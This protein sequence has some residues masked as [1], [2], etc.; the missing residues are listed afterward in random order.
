M[1][2]AA[3]LIV[4]IYFVLAL[5]YTLGVAFVKTARECVSSPGSESEEQDPYGEEVTEDSEG[6]MGPESLRQFDTMSQGAVVT[7]E[8]IVKR[9]DVFGV[10]LHTAWEWTCGVCGISQ[11][12]SPSLYMPKEDELDDFQEEFPELNKSEI[13]QKGLKIAPVAVVC[14]Q[15]QTRSQVEGFT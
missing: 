3:D 11:Y 4:I 9:Q 13:M 5:A 8:P 6:D 2:F 12:V 1:S 7:E 14:P 15:C 10:E